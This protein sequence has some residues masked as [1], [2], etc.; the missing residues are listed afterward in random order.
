MARV[1]VV[2][3]LVLIACVLASAQAASVETRE[4]DCFAVA[5]DSASSEAQALYLQRMGFAPEALRGFALSSFERDSTGFSCHT[6]GVFGYESDTPAV[7]AR[8]G[9]LVLYEVRAKVRSS[10]PPRA[11]KTVSVDLRFSELAATGESVQP[12]IKAIELAAAKAGWR[13]GHAW[14]LSMKWR[15]SGVLRAT[16]ALAP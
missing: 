1:A 12:G 11:K 3:A 4:V 13:S 15:G 9:G 5:Q 10:P 7:V 8:S 14:I 6:E 16:V 2:C